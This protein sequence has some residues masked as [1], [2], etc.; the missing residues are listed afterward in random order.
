[1]KKTKYRDEIEPLLVIIQLF[2]LSPVLATSLTPDA[3]RVEG[4]WLE[5]TEGP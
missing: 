5:M 2:Q 1:M 4:L 3:S